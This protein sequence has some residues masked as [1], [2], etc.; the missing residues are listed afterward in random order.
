ML[1]VRIELWP[2]GNRE[3]ARLLQEMHIANDA[4]GDRE[5]GNYRAAI[6]HSTTFR[7][8]GFAD[9]QRPADDGAVTTWRG[10]R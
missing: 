10:G 1:Y 6:S 2:F 3:R 7:G 5:A 4:T 8:N 9:P